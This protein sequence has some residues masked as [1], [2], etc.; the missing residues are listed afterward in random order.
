M[1][2]SA[3]KSPDFYLVAEHG[4][5]RSSLETY[6]KI[7]GLP[8]KYPKKPLPALKTPL[9]AVG[10]RIDKP[11]KIP[12]TWDRKKPILWL[13]RDPFAVLFNIINNNIW[14]STS[15]LANRHW[16]VSVAPISL[17]CF[18][19][20]CF[21]NNA[22]RPSK[23]LKSVY[24]GDR[25]KLYCIDHNS[26]YQD[27]IKETML[28]IGKF[29]DLDLHDAINEH[30]AK[31]YTPY[32]SRMGRLWAQ[33]PSYFIL[34]RFND[35]VLRCRIS[36]CLAHWLEFRYGDYDSYR[37]LETFSRNGEEF[38][39]VCDDIATARNQDWVG[40]SQTHFLGE[41]RWYNFQEQEIKPYDFPGLYLEDWERN[42]FMESIELFS[43]VVEVHKEFLEKRLKDRDTLFEQIWAD[44]E[45]RARMKTIL[46][47]ELPMIRELA[48]E[49]YEKFSYVHEFY[50]RL[51]K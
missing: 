37:V 24:S 35:F 28:S 45:L 43:T 29:L 5:G 11:M 44:V 23:G 40:M 17:R 1:T 22:L 48:P 18:L 27:K 19:Y 16:P 30:E 9:L 49:I 10:G 41:L 47:E 39:I 31:L 15:T 20:G 2:L 13:L 4:T 7:L 6:C 42:A 26:L 25:T 51:N 46:D 14:F 12:K 34:R 50:R 38:A 8:L 36:L 32:E 33:A 3:S 21:E